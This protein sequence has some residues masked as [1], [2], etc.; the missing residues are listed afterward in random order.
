MMTDGSDIIRFQADHHPLVFNGR[1][2]SLAEYCLHLVHQKAYEEAALLAAGRTVLDLGCNNGYGSAVLGQVC[3]QVTAL[4]VSPTAIQD[5]QARFGDRGIDFRVY[6]GRKIPF[7]DL[8]FDLV[9]SFQVIEH[10]EDTGP[11][12]T[13]IA[14]VLRPSG[15]AL[16]TTPNAA[17]RLD[18]DMKPWNEFHV[19]E[20][21]AA[22]LAESLKP[23]FAEVD[24]RGLFAT[25]EL[26]QTEYARC[27]S[28]LQTARNRHSSPRK[29]LA[30][31]GRDE[32]IR[33]TKAILP[34]WALDYL[35]ARHTVIPPELDPAIVQ[36]Y[37]TGDFFYKSDNLD[38]ALDLMAICRAAS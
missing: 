5:A 22:E 31:Q 7:D 23:V 1:F 8:S 36:K 35:R 34:S 3:R 15:V 25:E 12:L 14:R 26:Y 13:E 10:L 17:I 20:Y 30:E 24:I 33:L 9:V 6:D 21:R 27:Q 37:S 11:Y 2:G 38:E 19:R 28:A 32:L 18:R 16:F 29:S 4:D